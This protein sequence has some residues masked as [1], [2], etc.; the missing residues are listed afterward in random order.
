[1]A[2]YLDTALPATEI[3]RQEGFDVHPLEDATNLQ[4]AIQLCIVNL[5]PKK[6]ATETQLCRMLSYFEGPIVITWVAMESYTPKNTPMDHIRAF[7]K[8][9][10]EV[11]K[12]TF[13]G[14]I[15]TGSPVE[16]LDFES[17]IYWEE[18]CGVIDYARENIPS[19]LTIC[20]GAQAV[21]YR[22][23]DI[24]KVPLRQKLSGVFEL[25][26]QGEDDLTHGFRKTFTA[27]HSRYTEC[28]KKAIED[29]GG[30]KI[31]SLGEKAGVHM[32]KSEEDPFVFVFGHPE[33]DDDTLHLEYM[34]DLE[35]GI[36]IEMPW[37]YYCNNE[38]S[39]KTNFTWRDEGILQYTNWLKIVANK[40]TK[41]R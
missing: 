5:M 41:K 25:E 22:L 10:D 26:V 4:D 24:P 1:M 16:H 2:L 30:L 8:G 28:E 3:L 32:A 35:K 39:D 38:V 14:M 12:H 18:L 7:Y 33:Y 21:L 11:K 40:K 13:D 36:D 23:F 31:L 37:N 15:I 34:R 17:V 19:V 20:W 27:P 6:I 29:H 9:F